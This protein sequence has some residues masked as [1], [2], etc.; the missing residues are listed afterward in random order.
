MPQI[1][2][3]RAFQ[4]TQDAKPIAT[5]P[6]VAAPAAPS[7]VAAMMPGDRLRHSRFARSDWANIIFVAITVL[8]G[9][10]CAFYFFNGAELMRAA[11][12]WPAE[13]LYSPPPAP[14][15][16]KIDNQAPAPPTSATSAPAAAPGP[17]PR[18][19]Q[20]LLQP[21]TVPEFAPTLPATPPTNTTT[22]SPPT[23]PGP[24]AGGLLDP[25]GGIVPGG[26]ALLQTLNDE[27]ANLQQTAATTASNVASNVARTTQTPSQMLRRT[28]TST[29]KTIQNFKLRATPRAST[30]RN[31]AT[32]SQLR[33]KTALSSNA[34]LGLDK[35]G[36][37]PGVP[38]GIGP[39]VL[40][41]VGGAGGVGR[42][43]GV[44][45][46]GGGG[47]GIGGGVGGGLGGIGGMG[48]IG[49]GLPGGLGLGG[50]H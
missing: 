8:G 48:G 42:A 37:G 14:A 31:S 41:G 21:N 19:A 23:P 12:K 13:F 32:Q 46:G 1:D 5:F 30:A 7:H 10:F 36:I 38:G 16:A 2:F 20:S 47:V 33:T 17:F 6:P 22:S 49:G 4:S 39:E 11:A 29:K 25:I 26:D 9:L 44:G 18:S 34:Q 27:A 40:G 35:R 3:G 50:R 24:G 43:G 15:F 28:V 45:G